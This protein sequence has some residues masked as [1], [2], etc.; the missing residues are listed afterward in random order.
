MNIKVN[1]N[2]LL[3][4]LRP[5][6][7]EHTPLF[8]DGQPVTEALQSYVASKGPRYHK[9]LLQLMRNTLSSNSPNR[10]VADSVDAIIRSGALLSLLHIE[11]NESILP[12]SAGLLIRHTT[13]E[14][15]SR[16]CR[17]LLIDDHG[18]VRLHII[19]GFN[20]LDFKAEVTASVSGE[21]YRSLQILTAKGPLFICDF[22]SV[23]GFAA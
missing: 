5:V 17:N 21:S 20:A 14:L 4:E 3:S 12:A 18:C 19:A 1:M 16:I 10:V 23:T 8:R 11:M 2:T 22:T 7:T 6:T 15:A 13:A 9:E